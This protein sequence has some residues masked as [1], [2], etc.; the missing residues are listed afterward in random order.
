M[1][2]NLYLHSGLVSSR[3]INRKSKSA[4]RDANFYTAV[5]GAIALA[6]SFIISLLVVSVFSKGMHDTTYQEVRVFKSIFLF[7]RILFQGL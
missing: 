3:K 4:L 5:E 6:V 7:K 1:P 2:H